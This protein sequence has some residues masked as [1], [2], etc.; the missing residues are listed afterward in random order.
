VYEAGDD[1][2]CYPGTSVLRNELG[3]HDRAA[4]DAFEADAVRQR[5]EEPLPR[6]RLGVTHY[7]AVRHHLFQDVYPWAGRFRSV[8]IAKDGSMFCYPEHI[9]AQM[10]LAFAAL[11]RRRFL[12]GLGKDD[13]VAGTAEFLATLNAIHPF[14]EGNGRAQMSFVALLADRAGHPLD[15]GRLDVDAFLRAMVASF[16][17][18]NAML[19]EQIGMLSG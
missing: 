8:R 9:P 14:R 7:R 3:L 19:V 12:R 16:H 17:G 4:L 1:P 2:Y 6:G 13:F 11:R 18:D 10:A 5:G 15:L